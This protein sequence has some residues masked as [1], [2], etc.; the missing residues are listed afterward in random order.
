M[1]RLIAL[2]VMLVSVSASLGGCGNP[3]PGPEEMKEQAQKQTSQMQE[4]YKKMLEANKKG[5]K[6]GTKPQRRRLRNNGSARR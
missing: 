2:L 6:P 5:A 4:G 3:A 1:K